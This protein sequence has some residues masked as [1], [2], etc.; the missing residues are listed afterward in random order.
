MT[1]TQLSPA[2]DAGSPTIPLC[3]YAMI[4][5]TVVPVLS[6]VVLMTSQLLSKIANRQINH[7]ADAQPMNGVD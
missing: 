7:Q 1:T 4:P 5:C 6:C 3:L 2:S